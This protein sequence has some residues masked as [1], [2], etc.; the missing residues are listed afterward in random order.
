M[1]VFGIRLGLTMTMTMT[2]GAKGDVGVGRLTF[3]GACAVETQGSRQAGML[4]GRVVS[5]D[6]GSG[7]CGVLGA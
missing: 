5:C 1:D 4:G 7:L 2:G 6:G 3:D